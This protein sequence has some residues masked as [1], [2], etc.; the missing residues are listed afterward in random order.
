MH[1]YL[2][3]HMCTHSNAHTDGSKV[4]AD[5][6]LVGFEPERGQ[7]GG[8]VEHEGLGTGCEELAHHGNQEARLVEDARADNWVDS[9]NVPEDGAREIEKCTQV[10]L[11]VCVCV[12]VC[13]QTECLLKSTYISQV[14]CT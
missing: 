6:P 9:A 7:L 5:S 3:I 12:C 2:S 1:V 4:G 14:F 10:E 8:G 11:C 13:V